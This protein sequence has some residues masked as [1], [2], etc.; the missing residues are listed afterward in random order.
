[1]HVHRP[2]RWKHS[3]ETVAAELPNA[4]FVEVGPGNILCSMFGRGWTPGRRLA[5]DNGENVPERGLTAD[6]RHGS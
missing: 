1:M 3:V 6:L 2:V 4:H 5:A